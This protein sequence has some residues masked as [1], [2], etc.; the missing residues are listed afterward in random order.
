MSDIDIQNLIGMPIAEFLAQFAGANDPIDDATNHLLHKNLQEHGIYTRKFGDQVHKY[1]V[2]AKEALSVGDS[3]V[4]NADIQSLIGM[5][6]AE[7]INQFSGAEN[8]IDDA[9][10]CLLYKLQGAGTPVPQGFTD[11]ARKYLVEA[12]E[13][14][15]GNTTLEAVLSVFSKEVG[16]L[17]GDDKAKTVLKTFI[18]QHPVSV[19][20]GVRK[21]IVTKE[22]LGVTI[23]SKS[24][25]DVPLNDNGQEIY[26]GWLGSCT[27]ENTT[28]D[29]YSHGLRTLVSVEPMYGWN[30]KLNRPEETPY[31]YEITWS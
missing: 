21:F 25:V 16:E 17:L 6:I 19:E 18:Y 1:L 9:I 10:C 30:Y 26:E 27:E 20:I 13:A 23:E 28:T 7:F 22:L 31:G 8:P 15:I 4:S 24:C 11:Q 5:P 14:C 12:K 29:R 3:I 2:E